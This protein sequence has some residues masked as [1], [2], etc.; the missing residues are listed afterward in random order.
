M[1]WILGIIGLGIMVFIHEL[2]HFVAAKLNGVE[3]EVFSLGW[4]PRL[5]GFTSKGTTYQISWFPIGGYC[6][7]KGELV[8]SVAGGTK[9]GEAAD[10]A[11]PAQGS[12][13]A[14]GPWRRILIAAFGPCS[15]SSSHSSFSP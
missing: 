1:T 15:T 3:V 13:L 10:A 5:V 7:M 4:G 2:G 9:A 6:K 11:Q 8:P 12:F 14:A